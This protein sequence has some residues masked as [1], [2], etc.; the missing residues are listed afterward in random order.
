MLEQTQ[1]KKRDQ[2][3]T[4]WREMGSA[5]LSISLNLIPNGDTFGI[6]DNISEF[7]KKSIMSS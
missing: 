3:K 2:R 1:K 5:V 7:V 6:L 4:D